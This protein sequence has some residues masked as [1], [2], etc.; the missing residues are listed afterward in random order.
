MFLILFLITSIKIVGLPELVIFT[1]DVNSG[2]VSEELR[3]LGNQGDAWNLGQVNI[4]RYTLSEYQIRLVS[5][6]GYNHTSDVAIDDTQVTS[7]ACGGKY[8]VPQGSKLGPCM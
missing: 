2:K 1:Q 8:G 7:G 5:I 3:I 4:T 6:V